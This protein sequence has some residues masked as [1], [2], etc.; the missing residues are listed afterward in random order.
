VGIACGKA[1]TPRLGLSRLFGLEGPLGQARHA[2]CLCRTLYQQAVADFNV[3]S[4][5]QT[6]VS[7]E[8]GE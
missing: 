8:I 2:K 5:S 3:K 6:C 4:P 7:I 1:A